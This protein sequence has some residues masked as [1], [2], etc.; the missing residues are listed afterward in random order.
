MARA[1]RTLRQSLGVGVAAASVWRLL[2]G[3]GLVDFFTTLGAGF[4]AL[5]TLLVQ[6]V[7]GT[8][9]FDEGLLGS[10]AFLEAGADDAEIA[11]GGRRLP[12]SADKKGPGGGNAGRLSCPR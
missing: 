7:L 2:L 6:F 10:V 4:G 9:K 12:G 8:Q 11:A 3:H 5:L 1:S